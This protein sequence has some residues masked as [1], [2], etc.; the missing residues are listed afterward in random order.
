MTT[1]PGLLIPS[2]QTPIVETTGKINTQWYNWFKDF[3][4][5]AIVYPTSSGYIVFD[6]TNGNVFG[7]TFQA[8]STKITL[9][10]AD[11]LTANTTIDVSEAALNL[12]NLSG[13]LDVV[14]GGTG[15]TIY[16]D[17]QLLI[18][19]TV[20][21]TLAKATLTA[22]TG[23]TITNGSGTITISA[24]DAIATPQD[25]GAVG[26]GVADDTAAV[27]AAIANNRHIYIPAGSY[28]CTDTITITRATKITGCG[29]ISR[30]V[31]SPSSAKPGLKIAYTAT[32][33][34]LHFED[35]MVVFGNANMTH[36]LYV[37]CS[38]SFRVLLST[39]KNLYLYADGVGNYGFYHNGGTGD[40]FAQNKIKNCALIGGLLST[41]DWG[42]SNLISECDIEG[43]NHGI[44]ITA[45]EPG[46]AN[47]QISNNNITA[48]GYSVFVGDY[49]T[50]VYVIDNQ[51]EH[52][53]GAI[54]AAVFITGSAAKG[55]NNAFVI[56]NNINGQATVSTALVYIDY[57]AS[58]FI[59][60]NY[61]SSSV[62]A[63]AITLAGGNVS[64]T[65][66]GPKNVYNGLTNTDGAVNTTYVP[67]VASTGLVTQTS[68]GAFT[69]RTATGTANRITVTDGDGVAG[70][71][72]IDISATYVGQAT[73]TTLGTITTGTWTGTTIAIANGGTGQTT[74]INA[75]NA[76]S[77]LT[78]QGDMLY[79]DGTN[80]VR[81]AKSASATRYI[82]NTG[83]SNS[84][85]WDQVNM[86]NG[87]TG[88]LPVANGG[89]GVA[90][91]AAYSLVCGGTTGTGAFQAAGPGTSGY[92]LVATG[93]SSLPS[94]KIFPAFHAYVGTNQTISTAT[95]TK[96]TLDTEGFDTNSN[97]DSATNYRF[98]PT[99]AGKYFF[100]GQIYY[101]TAVDQTIYIADIYKNG[102]AATF[103][104]F[105]ASGTSELCA[106]T[107]CMLD[108]NGSTDYVELYTA[109]FSGSNKTASAGSNLTYFVGVLV[110]P[111]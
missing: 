28:L 43:V 78:T 30:L 14:R 96:L 21:G 10:N 93:A 77:P 106:P 72:T 24:S 71:P 6:F 88:T 27:Q 44:Y 99:V 89:T 83:S 63:T 101:S 33:S 7:R 105:H 100:H 92:I 46:S 86:A 41:S 12:N 82:A 25:Y 8:A 49:A 64:N 26:D 56:R 2:Q 76:L 32:D 15:Q 102:V 108:M 47:I 107:S 75:F 109:Q 20:G 70:N 61:F 35:F 13:V 79:N 69:T 60:D 40:Y 39:F 52:P 5:R 37:D 19:K 53:T 48:Q 4:S 45:F 91:Q 58:A 67:F 103:S 65:V 22:S 80:D 3:S 73:I 11:G 95:F 29:N 74:A 9:T 38:T 55:V 98:T 110:A 62:A 17:G 81:L 94:F 59:D 1:S 54:T 68:A 42:D 90:T 36:A 111:S 57:T 18:G 50:N 84:P 104:T 97:F 31:F 16:T 87:V 34:F 23:V 51:I 85:A 66:I